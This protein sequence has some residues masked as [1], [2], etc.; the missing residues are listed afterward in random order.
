MD[1]TEITT[2]E[3]RQTLSAEM[4][5][6]RMRAVEQIVAEVMIEGIH[7][8]PVPGVPG[9]K[10]VDKPGVEI[11]A[12]TF[13]LALDYDVEHSTG[14]DGERQ[15]VVKCLVKHQA[16]GAFLGSGLGE[17]ST[18]ETKYKWRKA[19]KT[20]YDRT[21]EDRRR[22][23]TYVEKGKEQN[24]FQVREENEDKANTA[25]KQAG[26]RAARDAVMAVLGVRGM[27]LG[28][29]ADNRGAK[30][31]VGKQPVAALLRVALLKGESE[32]TVTDLLAQHRKF[33]GKLEAMTAADLAW[34]FE[35]LAALDNRVD[36]ATGEVVVVEPAVDPQHTHHPD[37]VAAGN[38]PTDAERAVDSDDDKTDYWPDGEQVP[39][40][41]AKAFKAS[42]E[43]TSEA[44]PAA[45]D[46][47]LV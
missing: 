38:L 26:T 30:V 28:G 8:G 10:M 9:K 7:Y 24:V 12:A 36:P 4:L 21:A 33:T 2:V 18:A 27:V 25:L 5:L 34:L 6:T 45:P 11:L 31:G 39:G 37:D 22:L 19:G 46:G 42:R 41:D 14:A 29:A 40:M 35:G 20:E 32:K 13:Q 23:K 17:A 3:L 15:Y 44:A 43:P 1:S 16:T 47:K